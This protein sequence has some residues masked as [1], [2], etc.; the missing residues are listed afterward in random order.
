MKEKPDQLISYLMRIN[1]EIDYIKS[2]LKKSENQNSQDSQKK[3][4]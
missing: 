4:G 2:I 3:E 1:E